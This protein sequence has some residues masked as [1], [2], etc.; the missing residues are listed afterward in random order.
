MEINCQ[1]VL[2]YLRSERDHYHSFIQY[3]SAGAANDQ[4]LYY[5]SQALVRMDMAMYS[6]FSV[7]WSQVVSERSQPSLTDVHRKR[8]RK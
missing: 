5:I 6:F 2:Q 8:V 7:I 4:H 1:G 3:I